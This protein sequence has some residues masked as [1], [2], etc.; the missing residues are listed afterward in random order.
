MIKPLLTSF[1]MCIPLMC[2]PTVALASDMSFGLVIFIGAPLCFFAL[3]FALVSFGSPKTGLKLS[4]VLL[5]LEVAVFLLFSRE[6]SAIEMLGGWLLLAMAIT[7]CSISYAVSRSQGD[8]QKEALTL[9]DHRMIL[10][11]LFITF[12]VVKFL[13]VI[14]FSVTADDTSGSDVLYI[15]VASGLYCVAG[16]SMIYTTPWSFRLCVPLAGVSLIFIPL[17][18]ALGVYYLWFYFRHVQSLRS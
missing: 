7:V 2:I 15:L 14:Y 4:V 6:E 13:G 8:D 9:D 11:A 10:G 17:G 1:L 18:T 5:V 3:L 16:Y 12:G